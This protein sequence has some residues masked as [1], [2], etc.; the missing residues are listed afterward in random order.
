MQKEVLSF[1][2][3]RLHT[4]RDIGP[5]HSQQ[6]DPTFILVYP[7]GRSAVPRPIYGMLPNT[8]G[9]YPLQSSVVMKYAEW[10]KEGVRTG[11]ANDD[12]RTLTIPT[13]LLGLFLK[14]TKKFS[15]EFAMGKP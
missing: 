12:R 2:Y 9:G 4:W 14:T 10:R 13:V 3:V 15:I 11:G 8:L 5:L 1:Q 6:V 7:L